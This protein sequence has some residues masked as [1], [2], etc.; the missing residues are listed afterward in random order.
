[1]MSPQRGWEGIIKILICGNFRG[2]IGVWDSFQ[3]GELFCDR[4]MDLE[5]AGKLFFV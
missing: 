2:I 3:K 5:R 1:M 4:Q